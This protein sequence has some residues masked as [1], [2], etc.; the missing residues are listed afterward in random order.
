VR[1]KLRKFERNGARSLV[2]LALVFA[3]DASAEDAYIGIWS[4]KSFAVDREFYHC[5]M[6]AT[7]GRGR[8]LG[9][10]L[11]PSQLKVLVVDRSWTLTKGARFPGYYQ[12]DGGPQYRITAEL[13]GPD[14]YAFTLKPER[15]LFDR[16]RAGEKLRVVVETPAP[17]AFEAW[18]TDSSKA[19][20]RLVACTAAG[21][22]LAGA[23]PRP[24]P[25]PKAGEAPG[26]NPAP[27]RPSERP[28]GKPSH[29]NYAAAGTGFYVSR[30]GHIL[31]AEHVI[32]GCK[33]L[34]AQVIGEPAQVALVVAKSESDDLALLKSETAPGAVAPLRIGSSRLG[35]AVVLYGF[36]LVGTLA[37][38]GNLTAG[39]I[40]AL[41]GP[42]DDHRL[43]QISAPAQPGNSGGPVFD[44]RGRVAGVL[45]SSVRVGSFLRA[46]GTLPQNVNFAVKASIV[47]S[48]LEAHGVAP[49]PGGTAQEGTPADVGERARLFTARID[50][51]S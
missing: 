11:S 12:V 22:R 21:A 35:E 2:A 1:S 51:A 48:F 43:M 26:D 13:S 38:S 18:I 17:I 32:R 39:N 29:V 10:F 30:S 8:V 40:A 44:L 47:S 19:L 31:T 25:R 45:L 9:F 23:A 34:R 14:A 6:M 36:P 42:R 27:S 41:A 49:A 20:D 33:A 28:P 7:F 5:E 46:T 15:A 4:I 3:A 37:S 16:L 24:E 50:C